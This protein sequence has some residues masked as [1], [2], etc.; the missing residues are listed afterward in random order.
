MRIA[1]PA[2]ASVLLLFLV[3]GAPVRADTALHLNEALPGPARDWDGSGAFSS[4]DDEWVEVV[5]IGAGALDVSSFFLTDGDSIPRFAFAGTLAPGEHRVVYGGESLSWE[6]ATGHPAFG[7][8]LGNT[9]DA[10]LLW[11]VVGADSMVV[12]EYHYTSHEAAA[13]RA[14]GRDPD[15]VGSWVLFDSLDPYSGTLPPTGTGCVPS[16]GQPNQCST[17]PARRVTWGELKTLYH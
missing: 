2:A 7:L 12:D 4:R 16:P 14:I 1:S 15:G 8:S 9:G 13:D 6:K 10:I 3:A 17:T 5:N 11:Q